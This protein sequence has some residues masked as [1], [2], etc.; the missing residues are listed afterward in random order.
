[1]IVVIS[2][3]KHV[4]GSGN[5]GEEWLSEPVV[6]EIIFP[7][8][9]PRRVSEEV[10][11]DLTAD[12]VEACA[13]L[14]ISTKASAALSRRILQQVLVDHYLISRKDLAAQID[15]FIKL[16]DV[17][18]YL[19]EAVDAVRQVGNL[20]AH[21]IKNQHTGEIVPVELGEAEWLIEVLESLFDFA[22]VQPARLK[23]NRTALEAK[24]SAAGKPV[25]KRPGPKP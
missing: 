7:T 4:Q 24:L 25:L 18:S 8:S 14:P 20:A 16:P 12:Y 13:V 21:P 22:F 2:R 17:P 23:A 19:A 3:G 1:L 11:D 6:E 15:E 10:P 9:G 5:F